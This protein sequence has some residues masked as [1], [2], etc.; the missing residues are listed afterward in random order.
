LQ[1]RASDGVSFSASQPIGEKWGV[2]LRANTAS[3]SSWNI[4][5][6]IAGG[7]VLNDPLGRNPLDQ[8][9]LGAAWNRTNLSLYANSFA[10]PSETMIELYWA[11]TFRSRLQITPDVQL[12]LQPALAPDAGVAAVFTLRAALLL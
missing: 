5:S 11:T 8:I 9:G 3:N 2:F 7:G 10:R 6:S 12:Y 4:Q 1:P